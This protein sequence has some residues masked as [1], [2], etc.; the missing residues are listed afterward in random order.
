MKYTIL[1]LLCCYQALANPT[2]IGEIEVRVEQGEITTKQ[3]DAIIVPQPVDTSSG[4]GLFR[5]FYDQY[6]RRVETSWGEVEMTPSEGGKAKYWL[7]ATVFGAPKEQA[8]QVAQD[9]VYNALRVASTTARKMTRSRDM[10]KVAI[11][12]LDLA[13]LGHLTAK[14][15]ALAIFAGI[16]R[17]VNEGMIS[18]IQKID[19]V[20][21]TR[22]NSEYFPYILGVEPS[23]LETFQ[24]VQRN[25][26]YLISISEAGRQVW[27]QGLSWSRE[28]VSSNSVVYSPT[29][30]KIDR[31]QF[32]SLVNAEYPTGTPEHADANHLVDVNI[33]SGDITDIQ[34]SAYVVPQQEAGGRSILP[35]GI[36]SAIT[37][38][39]AAPEHHFNQVYFSH[40]K[41]QLGTAP[42][43]SLGGR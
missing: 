1:F 33:R 38:N 9:S 42:C 40:G 19:I 22:P 4:G 16:Q 2:R 21:P 23:M 18:A 36:I 31:Y 26:S 37:Q 29:G 41:L 32:A 35:G 27:D 13:E 34:A 8:F 17:F 6:I 24:E 20:I 43:H 15:H 39:G 3:V 14:G 7:N 25:K 5:S 28:L 10:I 30:N 11:P 12:A